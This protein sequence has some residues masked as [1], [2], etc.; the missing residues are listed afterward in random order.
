MARHIHLHM[1]DYGPGQNPASHGKGGGGAAPPAATHASPQ[2][3]AALQQAGFTKHKQVSPG[4]Y[5][6]YHKGGA[7]GREGAHTVIVNKGGS[8]SS[9]ANSPGY[10]RSDKT[11][12]HG[13]GEASL[14]RHLAK[15]HSAAPA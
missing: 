13:Q 3:H 10:A 6:E 11:V 9:H 14:H 4:S 8:W 5:T 12:G 1:H 2:A 15:Q 7:E